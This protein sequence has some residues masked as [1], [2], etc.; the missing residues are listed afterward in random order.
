MHAGFAPLALCALTLCSA[1]GSG[2]SASPASP[3][4]NPAPPPASVRAGEPPSPT[5]A[6]ASARPLPAGPPIS[7]TIGCAADFLV[8]PFELAR[9][10]DTLALAGTNRSIDG[11]QVCAP[12]AEWVDATGAPIAVAGFGCAEGPEAVT[13]EL[14]YEYSPDNGGNAAN[15]VYLRIHREDP[16]GCPTS[17]I[18]LARR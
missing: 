2:S 7:L 12:A 6:V 14:T 16:A 8:G 17:E 18:T 15:P 5:G 4:T 9:S 13:S 1:C 11:Q 3:A 10:G